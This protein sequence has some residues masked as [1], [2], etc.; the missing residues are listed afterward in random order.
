[1]RGGIL[2]VGEQLEESILDFTKCIQLLKGKTHDERCNHALYSRYEALG[3]VDKA[4][5]CCEKMITSLDKSNAEDY[6]SVL[7]RRAA[8]CSVC[9]MHDHVLRDLD[10]VIKLNPDDVKAR[11]QRGSI[12]CSK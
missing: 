1:M 10:E 8:L 6:A 7:H 9:N 4:L 3:E 11:H 12:L 2:L 5:T